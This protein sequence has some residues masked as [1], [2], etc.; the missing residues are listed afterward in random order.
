MGATGVARGSQLTFYGRGKQRPY[1]GYAA[2][3]VFVGARF[4]APIFLYAPYLRA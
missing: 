1:G 4:I 3:V 2:L